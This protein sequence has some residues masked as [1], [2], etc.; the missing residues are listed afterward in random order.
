VYDLALADT[1]YRYTID[2]PNLATP[3]ADPNADMLYNGVS[4]GTKAG[5][6]M[7]REFVT[8]IAARNSNY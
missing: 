4:N 7:R 3:P 1:T 6:M 5:R 8:M 2:D